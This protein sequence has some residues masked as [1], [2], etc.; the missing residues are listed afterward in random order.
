MMGTA[1]R[2]SK[3]HFSEMGGFCTRGGFKERGP[4]SSLRW[5]PSIRQ[6]KHKGNENMS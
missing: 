2:I 4:V 6:D 5:G 1:S 3:I